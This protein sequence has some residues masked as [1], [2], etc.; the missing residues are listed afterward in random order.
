MDKEE[1]QKQI[2]GL[3]YEISLIQREMSIITPENILISSE[4]DVYDLSMRNARK[5]SYL[6]INNELKSYLTDCAKED[7]YKLR[8]KYC[9]KLNKLEELYGFN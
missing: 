1:V 8:N 3:K 4:T 2:R 9:K 5:I 7:Y 6:C